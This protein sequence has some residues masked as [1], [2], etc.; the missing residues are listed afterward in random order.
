MAVAASGPDVAPI[1]IERKSAVDVA[2]SMR[3]GRWSRQHSAMRRVA[4]AGQRARVVY[5][6]EGDPAAHVYTAC[7]CGCR[8]IGACGNP[9]L[10]AVTS[11]ISARAAEGCEVLCWV[12]FRI[13]NSSSDW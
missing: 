6:I 10:E 9:N 8:G 12:K 7:G 13:V 11:A 2:A 3:D 5:L 1:L 4:A